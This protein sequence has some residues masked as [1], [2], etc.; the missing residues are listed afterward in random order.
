M[1]GSRAAGMNF[2]PAQV[3]AREAASIRPPAGWVILFALLAA[4]V[5]ASCAPAA[6]PLEDSAATTYGCCTARGESSAGFW[7]GVWHGAIA[8]VT[9]VISLFSSKIDPYEVHNNGGWYHLGFLLGLSMC[10]GGSARGSGGPARWRRR[11]R[12]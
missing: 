11:K 8:P 4:L 6:N 10:L 1:T 7:L 5:L 3:G 12:G 2:E 9:F